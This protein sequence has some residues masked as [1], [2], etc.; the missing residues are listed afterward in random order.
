MW[1]EV[2]MPRPVMLSEIEFASP[3]QPAP[4]PAPGAAA[5]RG[6]AGARPARTGP[7]PM[8]MT[9]PRSYRVEVSVDGKQWSAPV[10]QGKSEATYT[11]I[12]FKPVRARFVRVTQ[13]ATAPDS[14][15]WSM[16]KL[17]FYGTPAR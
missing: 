11:T 9:S 15:A 8:R 16:Q 14:A 7:P 13:T 17:Q 3:G 5:A 4:R 12:S 10:A 1:F 2:E 6:A